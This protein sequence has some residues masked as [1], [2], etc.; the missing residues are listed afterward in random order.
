MLGQQRSAAYGA[1]RCLSPR[2]RA[3][4]YEMLGPLVMVSW[5]QSLGQ[6]AAALSAQHCAPLWPRRRR[7]LSILADGVPKPAA[8]ARRAT[9]RATAS[10]LYP[11]GRC[12]TASTGL[13]LCA[14]LSS[15]G[16]RAHTRLN[17]LPVGANWAAPYCTVVRSASRTVAGE[18]A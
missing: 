14:G 17:R 10:S 11:C 4:A 6:P 18:V 7:C 9:L 1:D 8:G 16:F 5:S 13:R 12:T 3:R 15:I 2:P